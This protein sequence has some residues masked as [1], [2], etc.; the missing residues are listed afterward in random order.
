MI[1]SGVLHGCRSQL[2]HEVSVKTVEEIINIHTTRSR[3]NDDA[4]AKMRNVRDYY[5]GILL[6][7]YQN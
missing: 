6:F 7:R 4:K 5:N 3:I 1:D 2:T